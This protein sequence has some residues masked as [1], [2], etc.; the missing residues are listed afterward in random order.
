MSEL[1]NDYNNHTQG[2]PAINNQQPLQVGSNN[3]HI[4]LQK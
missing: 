2:V 3:G 1:V 4:N